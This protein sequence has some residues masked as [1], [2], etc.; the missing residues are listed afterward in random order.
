MDVDG[1]RCC[2]LRQFGVARALIPAAAA[3]SPAATP[4][5]RRAIPAA[6]RQ[7]AKILCLGSKLLRT[8]RHSGYSFYAAAARLPPRSGSSMPPHWVDYRADRTFSRPPGEQERA[9]LLVGPLPPRLGPL[10]S[11]AGGIRTIDPKGQVGGGRSLRECLNT[12]R[13]TQCRGSDGTKKM[14]A[15]PEDGEGRRRCESE[16][17][18]VTANG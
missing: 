16:A 5:S 3:D 17:R 7:A 11:P 2:L 6:I 10:S 15:V 12:E 13:V 14:S 1:R 18:A 8:S 9:G 4:E